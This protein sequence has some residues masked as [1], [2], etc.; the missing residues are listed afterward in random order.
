[1]FFLYFGKK[2]FADSILKKIQEGTFQAPKIKNR[3]LQKFLIFRE[4]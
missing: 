4:I 1:M 2:N 3:T